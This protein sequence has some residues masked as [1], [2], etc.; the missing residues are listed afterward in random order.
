MFGYSQGDIQ[1][2]LP[3]CLHEDTVL[4]H[5]LWPHEYLCHSGSICQTRFRSLKSPRPRWKS[6]DKDTHT[7]N[8]L[9]ERQGSETN[10][11]LDT[12]AQNNMAYPKAMAPSHPGESESHHFRLVGELNSWA[13]LFIK[14]EFDPLSTLAPNRTVLSVPVSLSAF[15]LHIPNNSFI[16]LLHSYQG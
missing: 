2:H 3:A 7:S 15:T 13:N 12:V 16:L 5:F 6:E 10:L 1:T 8:K 14:H 4:K 11:K 9:S